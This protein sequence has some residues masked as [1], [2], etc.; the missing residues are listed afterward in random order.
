MTV[1]KIY[2]KD[3]L[4]RFGVL[5]TSLEVSMSAR[6]EENTL[7]DV[8]APGSRYVSDLVVYETSEEYSDIYRSASKA[9][10]IV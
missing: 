8:L 2:L 6:A 1:E 5:C 3:F 10:M 7:F 4:A 9:R